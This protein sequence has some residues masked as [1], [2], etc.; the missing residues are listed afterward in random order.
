MIL[1]NVLVVLRVLAHALFSLLKE[2]FLFEIA[3]EIIGLNCLTDLIG[4]EKG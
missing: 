2:I 1:I 3:L 4:H